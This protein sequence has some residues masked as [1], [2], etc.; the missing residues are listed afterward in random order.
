MNIKKLEEVR[1][2]RNLSIEEL[3]NKIKMSKTG[4]HNAIKSG[5]FKIATLEKIAKVLDV[6]LS[7]F[8][9]KVQ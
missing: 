7:Y 4:L 5:I 1:K 2:S 8:L 3:A 9:M 6:P